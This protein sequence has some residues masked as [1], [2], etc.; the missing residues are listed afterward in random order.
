MK[1]N[2]GKIKIKISIEGTASFSFVLKNIKPRMQAK[3]I[4][5][6]FLLL[7]EKKEFVDILFS[8]TNVVESI[9]GSEKKLKNW[10]QTLKK[11]SK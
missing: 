9:I 6:A 3:I 5:V 4:K 7:A 10:V 11:I 8:D 2:I 1:S